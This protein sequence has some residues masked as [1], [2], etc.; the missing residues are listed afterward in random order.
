M[1]EGYADYENQ[2]PNDVQT[3]VPLSSAKDFLGSNG[4]YTL[5]AFVGYE[6]PFFTVGTEMFWRTNME[7][8]IKNVSVLNNEL[9]NYKKSDVQ[10]FG[11]SAFGSCI[12]PFPK[13][14]VFARYDY[15]DPNNS[16]DVYTNFSDGK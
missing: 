3:A 7:S 6:H 10:R 12:T 8:G 16:D 1:I 15:Y 14:K 5:K 9:S 2:N 11:F 13:L 4:Y